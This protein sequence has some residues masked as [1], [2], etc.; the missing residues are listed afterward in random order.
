M[1]GTYNCSDFGERPLRA[2]F[3]T[4]TFPP[5]INGV[6]A[7][8]HRFASGLTARGHRVQIVRP[9][10]RENYP[11]PG[12]GPMATELVRGIPLPG[13]PGLR[14]GLP[15]AGR[16]TALWGENLPDIL[17]VA[18]E[19]PLGW[20]SIRWAQRRGIP[21]VSGFHTNFHSYSSHYGLGL[22][23]R[24]VLHYLRGLHNRSSCTRV[25]M[26]ALK[27]E[28]NGLR[29]VNVQVLGRG[30]DASHFSPQHRSSALRKQWGA[31]DG[32]PVALYVGRLAPEKNVTLA[33]EAF[34]GMREANRR[35]RMVVVGDGPLYDRLRAMHSDV[36]FCGPKRGA[37]LAAHYASADIFL[38][39]RYR[40]LRQCGARGTGSGLSVL[41]FDHAAAG[42]LIRDGV[43]GWLVPRG[44]YPAFREKAVRLAG[45]NQSSVRKQ[46]R[47]T[48]ACC[49]WDRIIDRFEKLLYH[50]RGY[51]HGTRERRR[52]ARAGQGR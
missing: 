51:H 1:A 2:G 24:P 37:E 13:Y 36:I 19:G 35:C 7:T 45:A 22:L 44:R 16:L 11:A 29:F 4:E 6:A 26:A 50:C 15:A 47:V 40:N 23:R 48:A 33:L 17:Y 46:A 25:P 20:S 42:M 30:V 38:S 34:A 14:F 52:Y 49:D 12:S 21:I 39:Q 31:T 10:Q 27:E 3:V 28:L 41:A 5:E 43:N 32:T 9:R 18:T 8:V